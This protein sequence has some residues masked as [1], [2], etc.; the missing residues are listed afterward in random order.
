MNHADAFIGTLVLLLMGIV[1]YSVWRAKRG[2]KT[3]IRPIAGIVA[4]E[5]AIGRATEMG[6]P[7]LFVAGYT[8]IQA[9]ETHTAMSVLA[10]VGRLAARMRTQLVALIPIP[11]VYP[12]AEATLRQAYMSEGAPELFQPQEQVRFLSDNSVVFAAGVSRWVEE[13]NPGCVIFFGGFD[14][15]ALLLSEPGARLRILQIAGDPSLFQ[16]PFFV[17]TCDHTI[18]GEE[19]YAAGAYVS[20]DPK[21]RNSLLGQDLV[22]LVFVIIVV[23]GLLAMQFVPVKPV[24]GADHPRYNRFVEWLR[25]YH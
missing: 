2:R 23:A 24:A 4:L 15:T 17:C 5:E 9:I 1:L 12:L 10:H 14:F 11:N 25:S 6:R 8:D 3:Y 21:M 22:K 13:E 20:P 18:I 16:M 7:I 19:F